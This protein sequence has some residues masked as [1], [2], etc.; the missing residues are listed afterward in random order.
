MIDAVQLNGDNLEFSSYDKT[1]IVEPVFNLNSKS[2]STAHILM[3]NIIILSPSVIYD[4]KAHA[5]ALV[6]RET[7]VGLST[8]NSESAISVFS[9][10]PL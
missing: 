7:C 3:N 9:C 4:T 2:V 10:T 5:T 8:R 6:Y 1:F